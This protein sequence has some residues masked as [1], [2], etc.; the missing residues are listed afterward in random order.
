MPATLTNGWFDWIFFYGLP[1]PNC[2]NSQCDGN[3]ARRT[4]AKAGRGRSRRGASCSPRCNTGALSQQVVLPFQGHRFARVRVLARRHPL[5]VAIAGQLVDQVGAVG[6]VDVELG[7]QFLVAAGIAHAL[8]AHQ[9][10]HVLYAALDRVRGSGG[11]DAADVELLDQV[12][13]R[14]VAVRHAVDV[15][16]S[17]VQASGS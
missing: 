2:G 16:M 4:Q 10:S 14:R 8:H 6:S 15:R 12:R 13:P 5:D 9:V 17:F 7:F 1:P 11:R 3:L